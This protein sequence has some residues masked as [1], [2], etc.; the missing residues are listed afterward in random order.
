MRNDN[1]NIG[2]FDIIDYNEK[3]Q[4]LYMLDSLTSKL[5]N[6]VSG[7][8][9]ANIIMIEF[10]KSPQSITTLE[11]YKKLILKSLFD[12]KNS[13]RVDTTKGEDFENI[14]LEY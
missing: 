14:E 7:V 1:K 5:S 9:L 2:I 8:V 6:S 13:N 3:Q 10:L 11:N 12:F 4:V